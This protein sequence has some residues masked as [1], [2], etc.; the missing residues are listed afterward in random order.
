M[1]ELDSLS[2]G[3]VL[4]PNWCPACLLC[5]F[6]LSL[7]ESWGG[8]SVACLVC[9]LYVTQMGDLFLSLF[10]A[11]LH[12]MC[13]HAMSSSSHA[14]V[15]VS[16]SHRVS[17]ATVCIDSYCLFVTQAPH[18][19]RATCIRQLSWILGAL[20]TLALHGYFWWWI[21]MGIYIYWYMFYL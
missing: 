1:L 13:Y 4:W 12:Y 2:T 8:W 21:Y 10:W 17:I 7:Y 18:G 5:L 14:L 19:S 16:M 9:W 15:E 3:C 6:T 20:C 11:M